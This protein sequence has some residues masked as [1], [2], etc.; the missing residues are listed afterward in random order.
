MFKKI[1]AKI[2]KSACKPQ[3]FLFVCIIACA[4]S[5]PL[6]VF[7]QGADDNP[8]ILEN[9][10]HPQY[11]DKNPDVPEMMIYGA[12]AKTL[13]ILTY[14]DDLKLEWFDGD[15]GK[16]KATVVTPYGIYDRSTKIIKGDK[17][18]KM[19]SEKMT[20]E[21]VGFVADPQK[22]TIYIKSNVKVVLLGDLDS[23]EK[24][25]SEDTKNNN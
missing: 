7:P 23:V 12:K 14:L 3:Y 19:D 1:G 25:Q 5:A 18:I 21:G 22:K 16:I 10:K 15:L 20:V 13:G 2:L 24:K 6:T 9:F 17:E 8:I 4:L 11:G